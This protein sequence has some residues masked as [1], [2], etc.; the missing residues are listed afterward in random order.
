M[1]R[2]DVLKYA[3][4]S[5]AISLAPLARGQ[6][7]ELRIG[8][9][10]ANNSNLHKGMLKF[11]QTLF[12]E[13][14]GRYKFNV[15]TDS[16][17]GDIAQ[18]LTGMQLGTI[19]MALLGM[20]N[21]T[22]LKGGAPL[23]VA[24]VP[25]LFRSKR[26]TAKVVNGPLFQPI[27][28]DIANQSG[29]RVF[30]LDGARSPRALQT[31]RGPIVKPEDLKGMRMRVPPVEM[32]R[33][34]F[35]YLGVKAV[36]TGV[37]DVYMALQKGQVE[38]QD[39]GFDLSLTFKWHEVAKY[40]SATDHNFEPCG[41][42]IG[43]KL[44]QSL[45]PA[46]R[47]LFRKATHDGGAVITDLGDEIDRNGIETLRKFGVA[48]TQPDLEPWRAALRDLHKRYDGNV[49]PAGMVEKIRALPENT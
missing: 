49:W 32:F 36:P 19:D 44:W 3:A 1:K 21:A 12:D 25:Y 16:Q 7:R 42:Y 43:E 20:A 47:D 4:G 15:Y 23:G 8:T 31:I 9:P 41:W 6:T 48:Y 26:G 24:Y 13:S 40:W 2:R 46:D 17:I 33:A 45:P 30:V 5:A 11:S 18:L 37:A 39:N 35:D 29:V 14:K 22:S 10:F 34:M 27:F 38:G 28:E